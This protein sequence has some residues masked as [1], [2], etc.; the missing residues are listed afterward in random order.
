MSDDSSNGDWELLQIYAAE[1]SQDAFARLVAR[2]A[3]LVFHT[4]LRR[5]RRTEL[6]ED[7][8]QAVFI[9]L[10]RSAGRLDPHGSLGAWLHKTT[11]CAATSALRAEARRQK[12][13]RAA[14]RSEAPPSAAV[15][16]TSESAALV[17][18][19]L[20]RLGS[21]DRELL[22]LHYLE[23]RTMAQTATAMGITVEAARKRLSR[24]LEK[25]RGKLAGRGEVMSMAGITA[26]MA[27]IAA[28]PG[29]T[30]ASDIAGAA[31]AGGSD[32]T[33]FTLA[34]ELLRAMRLLVLK[35]AA[36]AVASVCLVAGAMAVVCT[37]FQWTTP[38]R[39]EIVEY[40]Q[41][42][43][44]TPGAPD[45]TRLPEHP[46][47]M[48]AELR[49]ALARNSGQLSPIT[50]AW[51]GR[52]QSPLSK[53][54]LIHVLQISD[55][56]ADAELLG[57]YDD[58]FSFQDGRYRGSFQSDVP[59]KVIG[60]SAVGG[61][62]LREWSFDG[63][64][65]LMAQNSGIRAD[66][67][68]HWT[69]SQVYLD[70]WSKREPQ[71]KFVNDQ[72]FVLAGYHLSISVGELRAREPARTEIDDLLHAGGR[73]AGIEEV[74]AESGTKLVRVRIIAPDPARKTARALPEERIYVFDLDPQLNYAV[75]RTEQRTPEGLLFNSTECSEFQ[76][77]SGRDLYLPRKIVQSVH[78]CIVGIPKFYKEA[79]IS[80][81]L[82]VSQI[83]V[84][85]VPRGRFTIEDA[86]NAQP[87]T[88]ATTRPAVGS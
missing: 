4:A 51:S 13:E 25:L 75:I 69:I 57:R 76:K 38:V 26:T 19:A 18:E 43:E 77:L 21:S 66:G 27:G 32:G 78:S 68:V 53:G 52:S 36:A 61:K 59:L 55:W 41:L 7:V 8:T 63:Q 23:G 39:A 17:D 9:A 86:E 6:A 45:A 15:D 49:A 30:S 82:E 85:P 54:H 58:T 22:S 83:D 11:L 79:V 24:A 5:T 73:L 34:S 14:A 72:Y 35:K 40:P 44:Q 31:V 1:R 67:S 10:A 47:V 60:R 74:A 28:G 37:Q 62:Q 50:V 70:E 64:Q 46:V 33:A 3:D 88:R 2:Y 65:L 16:E 84:S 87:A 12:H 42:A 20:H 56:T 71:A 48:P 80:N 29:T 81:V